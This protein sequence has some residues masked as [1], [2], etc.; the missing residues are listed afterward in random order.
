MS[1]FFKIVTIAVQSVAYV[2]GLLILG[3]QTNVTSCMCICVCCPEEEL[4]SSEESG[5]DWS[6]LER[7]AAEADK[8]RSDFQD[9]YAGTDKK[10]K[11]KRPASYGGRKDSDRDRLASPII[12]ER[13]ALSFYT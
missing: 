10:G 1:K 5:K 13:N 9:E 12:S 2:N 7:E 11:G 3:G 8:E 6:D 4:G